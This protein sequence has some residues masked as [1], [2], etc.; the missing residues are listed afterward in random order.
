MLTLGYHIPGSTRGGVFTL[1]DDYHRVI[2]EG[3]A[4]QVAAQLRE[5]GKE[6]SWQAVRG[7]VIR[8]AKSRSGGAC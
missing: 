2:R 1:P 5:S 6:P 8:V 3:D 7:G 4:D